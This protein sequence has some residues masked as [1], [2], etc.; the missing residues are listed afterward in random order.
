MTISRINTAKL[1]QVI[2]T[3]N[4]E[5]ATQAIAFKNIKMPPSSPSLENTEKIVN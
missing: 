5:I 2:W 3:K 1:E 4:H